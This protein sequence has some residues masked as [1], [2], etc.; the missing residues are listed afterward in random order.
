MLSVE[1]NRM[2]DFSIGTFQEIYDNWDLLE[3][4][5]ISIIKNKEVNISN[6]RALEI[7]NDFRNFIEAF[8]VLLKSVRIKAYLSRTKTNDIFH[9]Y[10]K[11]MRCEY[12]LSE[13]VC[14]PTNTELS[15]SCS[16]YVKAPKKLF[17]STQTVYVIYNM[18][19]SFSLVVIKQIIESYNKLI[20]I[21]DELLESKKYWNF[22]KL[23]SVKRLKYGKIIRRLMAIENSDRKFHGFLSVSIKLFL[24]ELRK[25][26]VNINVNGFDC[27]KIV[28][29]IIKSFNWTLDCNTLDYNK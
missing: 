19:S 22:E 16:G 13:L 1:N 5:A 23:G 26:L 20:E 12:K 3:M 11:M 9:D 29:R 18:F 6:E 25:D 4:F 15:C 14:V 8:P 7:V 2:E 27:E 10:S 21:L 17:Y 28:R 24:I